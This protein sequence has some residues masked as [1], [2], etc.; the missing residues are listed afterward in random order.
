VSGGELPRRSGQ[1][2][3]GCHRD[4]GGCSVSMDF[5]QTKEG[6]ERENSV[7][8]CGRGGLVKETR[9]DVWCSVHVEERR[10]ARSTC[11]QQGR[12]PTRRAIGGGGQRSVRCPLDP[13]TRE[14]DGALMRGARG[15][16][17]GGGEFDSNTNFK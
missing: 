6:R 2:A 12:G 14:G 16:V 11:T 10:G 13:E 1:K 4:S 5:A 7:K 3:S 17:M 15:K 8:F 9:G